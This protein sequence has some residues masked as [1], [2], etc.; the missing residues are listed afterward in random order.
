MQITVEMVEALLNKH[1]SHQDLEYCE[2][3]GEPGYTKEF[4]DKPILF[5]NWNPLPRHVIRRLEKQ[6][7]LEWSDEW[8]I[9]YNH[10][11]S[12]AFRC[13]PDCYGWTP[14]YVLVDC[15]IYT[16]QELEENPEAL[17]RYIEEYLLDNHRRCD[18]L[19]IKWEEH[20]F[21]QINGD[22]ESGLYPGQTDD[23][24]KIL[25]YW[26]GELPDHEFIFGNYSSGQFDCGY[27]LYGRKANE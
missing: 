1:G 21:R 2:E 7:D 25:R 9:D 5:A 14:S 10:S 20:G 4:P 8:E 17:E 6:F 22:F 24:R 11:G 23:P 13:S 3:Y 27:N 26:Q 12:R 15:E 19:G 18:L 16:K